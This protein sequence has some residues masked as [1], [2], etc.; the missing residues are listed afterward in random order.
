MR[1]TLASVLS[2]SHIVTDNFTHSYPLQKAEV[3]G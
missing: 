2:A 3:H 1:S